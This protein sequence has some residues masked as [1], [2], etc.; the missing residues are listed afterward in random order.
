MNECRDCG[1]DGT[2][3]SDRSPPGRFPTGNSCDTAGRR[4]R[5]QIKRFSH[6][7]RT[8]YPRPCRHQATGY[9]RV[10]N[11]LSIR[12]R[13]D[14]ASRGQEMRDRPSPGASIRLHAT[15]RRYP[16]GNAAIGSVRI[17]ESCVSVFGFR[18]EQPSCSSQE[19]SKF[20]R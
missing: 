16:C 3:M 6:N 20:L 7:L 18:A 12:F 13:L 10:F 19:Q 9:Q 2:D 11:K 5:L 15:L 14:A 8:R 1:S 4:C 17:L